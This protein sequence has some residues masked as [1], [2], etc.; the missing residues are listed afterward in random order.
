MNKLDLS[1]LLFRVADEIV[2]L[3]H[4]LERAFEDATSFVGFAVRRLGARVRG[5]GCDSDGPDT[6]ARNAAHRGPWCLCRCHD[7]VIEARPLNSE[8]S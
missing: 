5:C 2:S 3:P 7:R 1:A 8:V 4:T 6:C